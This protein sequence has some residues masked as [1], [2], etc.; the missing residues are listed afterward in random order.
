[1][2]VKGDDPAL[3]RRV[4]FM[5]TADRPPTI[6]LGTT[7][8][9]DRYARIIAASEGRGRKRETF[10]V[11]APTLAQLFGVLAESVRE[12]NDAPDAAPVV[13]SMHEAPPFL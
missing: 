2:T 4:E 3:W 12:P 7:F 10:L 8:G 6:E 5:L 13:S 9:G 11:V 1:M